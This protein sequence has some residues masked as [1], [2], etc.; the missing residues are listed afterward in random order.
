MRRKCKLKLENYCSRYFRHECGGYLISDFNIK[1][2]R[3]VFFLPNLSPEPQTSFFTKYEDFLLVAIQNISDRS[4]ICGTFHSHPIWQTPS[5]TDF[6][7]M[8][9]SQ[10]LHSQFQELSLVIAP[11][12]YFLTV[13]KKQRKWEYYFYDIYRYELVPLSFQ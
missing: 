12:W 11:E 13:A 7:F 3:D 10:Q 6:Q 1:V 9:S 5:P 8:K 4:K 2:I